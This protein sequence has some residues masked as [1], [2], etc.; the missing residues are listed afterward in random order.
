MNYKKTSTQL[1]LMIAFL[2]CNLSMYAQANNNTELVYISTNDKTDVSFYQLDDIDLST[3]SDLN[4]FTI[5][6]INAYFIAI[7]GIEVFSYSTIH[8][9]KIEIKNEDNRQYS[10][11][12]TLLKTPNPP[13]FK[14]AIL[15]LPLIV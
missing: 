1:V 15:G 6:Q 8:I 11:I 13:F 5:P 7:D 14:F 2:F 3:W 10:L 9:A 12:Y 4:G